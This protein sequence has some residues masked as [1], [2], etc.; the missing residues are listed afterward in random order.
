MSNTT[1][2]NPTAATK[3][4]FSVADFKVFGERYGIDYR[5]P[6]LTDTS[7]NTSPVLHGDVEEMILP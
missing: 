4:T 2:H 7:A 6:L 1:L 3:K 5:F